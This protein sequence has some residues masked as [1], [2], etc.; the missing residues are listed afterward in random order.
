MNFPYSDSMILVA[1]LVLATELL[2][3]M[4]AILYASI[5]CRSGFTKTL[6]AKKMQKV[7]M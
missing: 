6:L 3:D 7:I 1:L 5:V 2:H 4:K